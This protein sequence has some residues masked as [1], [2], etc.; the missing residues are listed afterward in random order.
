MTTWRLFSI[1][2]AASLL[3]TTAAI[4]IALHSASIMCGGP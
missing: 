4:A 2:F 3:G 1:M